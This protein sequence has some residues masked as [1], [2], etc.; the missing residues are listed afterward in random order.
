M[1]KSD[2]RLYA[3]SCVLCGDISHYVCPFFAQDG[4]S[5]HLPLPRQLLLVLMCQLERPMSTV[6]IA[7]RAPFPVRSRSEL[8]GGSSVS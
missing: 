2:R 4:R 6:P 3:Y 8:A 5:S 7:Y 1:F